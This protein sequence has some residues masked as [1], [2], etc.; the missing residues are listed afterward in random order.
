MDFST[1]PNT[2]SFYPGTGTGDVA[3]AL[4]AEKG[5]ATISSTEGGAYLQSLDLYGTNSPV[6]LGEANQLW[7]YASQRYASGASGDVTA[8]L[9]NP[10]AGR[11]YLSTERPILLS[12]PGVTSPNETTIPD[13]FLPAGNFH[14]LVFIGRRYEICLAE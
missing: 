1:A 14:R 11:I 13:W 3:E 6:S 2:A 4:A 10:N 7:T 8:I 5:L 9:N 12:N